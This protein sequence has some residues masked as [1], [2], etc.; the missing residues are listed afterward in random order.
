MKIGRRNLIRGAAFLGPASAFANLTFA[1]SIMP[2]HAARVSDLFPQR[3]PV[4]GE[5]VDRVAFGINGWECYD[6]ITIDRSRIPSP[7]SAHITLPDHEVWI[8]INQ[9]W[10]AT[11]R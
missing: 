11:W 8:G 2:T 5:D 7:D 4:G 3:P 9:S 1:S 10:R 6:E